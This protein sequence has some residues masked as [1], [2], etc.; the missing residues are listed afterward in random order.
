MMN[1][2]AIPLRSASLA[3]RLVANR[4]LRRLVSLLSLPALALAAAN[5]QQYN[6]AGGGCTATYEN[7]TTLI[8]TDGTWVIPN[9][10]EIPGQWTVHIVCPQLD[11]TLL[12]AYSPYYNLLGTP[13]MNVPLLPISTP[14]AQPQ[15]LV[16]TVA[17]GSLAAAGSQ[18]QLAALQIFA[19]GS[20]QD[21][22]LA[23][24]GTTYFSSNPAVA[25]ISPDGLVTAV[26]AGSLTVTA[27]NN[28]L[29]ATLQIP[30]FA[31]LDS[32]GDGMPDTWEIANGLNPYDPTDAALDPDGDGLTNLQ[33]YQ[34]GTN[35]HVADTDGDGLTD[36]QEVKLGTN[37]L[38]ADTDG[39]GLSDGQ[40]V[41]F[42]TNPLLADTDGDGIPDGVE[43]KIGT[44]P[45]VP[46]TTTV[47]TG[48][49][50]NSDGT[51][52]VGTSTVV[53]TYFNALTDST[54]KFTILTVPVTLGNVIATAEAVINTK[55]Y[56][57][58]TQSITP[59]PNGVTNV[60]TIVLG[61]NGGQVSGTVTTPDK[62]PDAGVRVLVTGGADSRS[63]VTDSNG[64]YSVSG[65]PVGQVFV[66]AIDPATSLRGQATGM[67][68]GSAP[69]NLS[70]QLASFGTVSG[71]VTDLNNNPVPAGVTV[72]ITGALNA[73]TLTDGVG[74]YSFA[75]VPLGAVTLDATD[76]NGNHGR[77]Q[78]TVTATA[79]TIV[80]NL[81]Y[82]GQGT[83]A[84]TV[85]DSSGNVS[86][87][88]TVTL[89]NNGVLS[90]RLTTTAN[91]VGQYSIPHVF[92]GTLNLT[93]QSTLSAITGNTTAT[94]TTNAQN[95]T[96][97]ITLQPTGTLTGVVYRVD[98][99][100]PVPNATV[101]LMG[102]ALTTTAGANG[103]YTL[104]AVPLGTYTVSAADPSSPD[105]GLNKATLTTTGLTVTDNVNL[106]GL[107]S[108]VVTVL[109]GGGNP[110]SGAATVINTGDPTYQAQ[111]GVTGADGTVTFH[112]VL[113]VASLAASATNPAT[114]LGGQTTA[115][116]T[117][118][119]TVPVT[120]T[121]QSAGTI[122]GTVFQSD[123][124]TPVGGIT[125]ANN[126]GASTLTAANGTYALTGVPSGTYNVGVYDAVG[127][128]LSIS[129]GITVSTQGQIVTANF[130]IVGRGT[131][132][133]NVTFSNGTAAAGVSVQIS[134]NA[135]GGNLYGSA[136]DVNGNY[137]VPN[138]P[139]GGYT[140]IGQQ[141]TLTTNSYGTAAGSL[142][143]NG[144]TSVTKCRAFEYARSFFC[145]L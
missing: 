66:A 71:N 49:V 62:K 119:Q 21:A 59:V 112:N 2:N 56:S 105:A 126:N 88:A 87:G 94:V 10:P 36:G 58:S 132:T 118:N 61:Q 74:H 137:S 5:A 68:S 55:V 32:D 15:G 42:G 6:Y 96:A 92:I 128:Q 123:G 83:V 24:E 47:I 46:D 3:T 67:L 44:N 30:S 14:F 48:Y 78:G 102:T 99:I 19:S 75:F 116:L 1:S 113:A 8:D 43:V 143:G 50:T 100:T 41:A 37:P 80:A 144:A 93:A 142:A 25:T 40:E 101:S 97:N 29:V 136:T 108:V 106:L 140:A 31:S 63:T 122:Q 51:P 135:T 115:A 134:S 73:S 23:A 114:G 127:N 86:P 145:G 9:V 82:L 76:T 124:A 103:A 90:Q 84:G 79:Q 17:S 20:A 57:G 35:P 98:G 16:L 69:L 13:G 27:S 111:T 72:T 53:L 129:N 22:T 60:G 70:V 4:R 45:L 34:L 120:I 33:E 131:V 26:G 28:G 117:A 65:L 18:L 95:V 138:V 125:V 54:G 39:D 107:S 12:D 133:G 110:N 130:V 81:Q 11:G 52:S 139:I 91:S 38:L 85:A 109:D 89:V 141:H 7:R 64:L 77:T 121:L 104:P